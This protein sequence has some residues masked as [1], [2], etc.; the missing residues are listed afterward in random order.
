MLSSNLRQLEMT[1][2]PCRKRNSPSTNAGKYRL[3]QL[4]GDTARSAYQL[5]ARQ[6]LTEYH[7]PR[8]H[9]AATERGVKTITADDVLNSLEELDWDEGF[10]TAMR[11]DMKK[12]LKGM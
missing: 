4:S 2:R 7:C 8:A 5:E 10:T 6:R 1:E 3:R 12:Q 11:K 9:E